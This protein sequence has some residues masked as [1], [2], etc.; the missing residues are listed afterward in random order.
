MASQAGEMVKNAMKEKGMTQQELAVKIGKDQTLISRFISGVPIADDTARAMAEILDLNA[1]ELLKLLQ[2][3]KYERQM[4]K[5]KTQFKPVADDD[6]KN[7]NNNI[8]HV[9]IVNEIPQ[10]PLLYSYSQPKKKAGNYIVP[11]G[12]Q[13]DLDNSFAIFANEKNLT[14]DKIEDDD[15]IIVDSKAKIKDGDRVLVAVN[16]KPELRRFYRRGDTV[17]LQSHDNSQPPLVPLP[18]DNEIKIIG[19]VVFLHKVFR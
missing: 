10:I 2:R 15:I 8:G 5:L 16:N 1:D 12:I 18:N 3:E 13:L 14:D 6:R 9:G 4:D 11:T 17:I 7:I 19:R